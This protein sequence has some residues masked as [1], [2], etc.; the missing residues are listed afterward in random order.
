M[1]AIRTLD[2]AVQSREVFR[3]VGV[4]FTGAA[5]CTVS[6]T[7][8]LRQSLCSPCPAGGAAPPLGAPLKAAALPAPLPGR[9]LRPRWEPGGRGPSHQPQLQPVFVASSRLPARGL[10]PSGLLVGGV[11]F[12]SRDCTHLQRPRLLAGHAPA[13]AGCKEQRRECTGPSSS[14][15]ESRVWGE[16]KPV[17]SSGGGG[18][19]E[20]DA[21]SGVS[22]PRNSRS[23]WHRTDAGTAQGT[24]QPVYEL[25]SCSREARAGLSRAHG[26][27]RRA[28]APGAAASRHLARAGASPRA[29]VPRSVP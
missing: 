29:R 21:A 4:A 6:Q 19:G 26:P 13:P 3:S 2:L 20:S 24:V 23:R 28:R 9:P 27:G 17:S 10:Q 11:V 18:S 15:S 8:H 16:G 25:G 22:A 7:A 12:L 1:R 5:G 14:C